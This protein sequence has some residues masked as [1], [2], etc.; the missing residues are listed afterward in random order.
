ML[1]IGITGPAGA[2]KD[3][4]AEYLASKLGFPHS[5]G[6]DV[7]RDM[8][9]AMDLPVGKTKVV[10]MGNFLRENYGTDYIASRAIGNDNKEGVIY[11]G[12]RSPAEANYAKDR[13]GYIIYVDAPA[14]IRHERILKRRRPDDT[15]DKATLD[16][17][18]KKELQA[19]NATGENL[20]KIRDLA[21][22]I[23]TNDDNLE[24]LHHKLDSIVEK[25]SPKVVS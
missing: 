17:I 13:G 20:E 19:Q 22:F 2:G 8:L 6:G 10:A 12:F 11:S 21:D 18:D 9:R 3:I 1:I 5:S 4:S 25:I 16:M 23:V 7:I 14:D 24:D 15:T